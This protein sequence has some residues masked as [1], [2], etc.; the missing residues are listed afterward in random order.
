MWKTCFTLADINSP[1]WFLITAK[2]VYQDLWRL[3]RYWGRKVWVKEIFPGKIN[4]IYRRS[5]HNYEELLNMKSDK[6][7]TNGPVI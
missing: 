5:I 3:A 4:F 7:V 6:R 2:L 1:H